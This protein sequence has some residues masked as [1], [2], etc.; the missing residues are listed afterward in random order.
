MIGADSMSINSETLVL[1]CEA[2]EAIFWMQMKYYSQMFVI[3]RYMFRFNE[4]SPA[5]ILQKFKKQELNH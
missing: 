2:A 3:Q 4:T 5:I 1:S